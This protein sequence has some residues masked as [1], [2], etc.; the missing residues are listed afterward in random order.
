MLFAG[1]MCSAQFNQDEDL[2]LTGIVDPTFTDRGFQYG[3][4]VRK[5]LLWGWVGLETTRYESLNPVY[6]DLVASGGVSIHPWA[7]E[8]TIYGGPRAGVLWRGK[9]KYPVAGIGLGV[10]VELIDNIRAGVRLWI[11]HREDQ[12]DEF[13]GDSSGYERGILTNNSLLQENGAL[14]LTWVVQ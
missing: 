7:E 3:I 8:V 4:Q 6:H 5:E 2:M 12:K 10:D 11:D 13:Y 14:T 9:D 1:L